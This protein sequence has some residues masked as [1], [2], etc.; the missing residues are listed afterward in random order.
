M[1]FTTS[2]SEGS[3]EDQF[4]YSLAASDHGMVIVGAPNTATGRGAA[5]YVSASQSGLSSIEDNTDN[6]GYITEESKP[7]NSLLKTS[8]IDVKHFGASVAVSASGGRVAVSGSHL[9]AAPFVSVQSWSPELGA[10]AED[11]L[12][13]IRSACEIH[14]IMKG[15]PLFVAIS[16]DVV[17]VGAPWLRSLSA[18]GAVF[19]FTPRSVSQNQTEY[20][21]YAETLQ[22]N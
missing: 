9:K 10:Y 15:S 3:D 20:V 13:D 5:Y 22:S 16:E 11:H 6:L 14:D 21:A 8:A 17:A 1:A 7:E 18:P 4:G 12:L 2:S 19:L